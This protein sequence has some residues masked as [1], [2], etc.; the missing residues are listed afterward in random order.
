MEGCVVVPKFV[1]AVPFVVVGALA[2]GLTG[3]EPLP[4]RP[5]LVG[6]E[7]VEFD[8]DV[9]TIHQGQQIQFVNNSNFLHVLAPGDHARVS[10]GDGVPSFG[11]DNVRS[12]PRG[13][14][15]VTGAW[16][17]PGTYDLTCTLHPGMNLEVV[18]EG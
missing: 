2:P 13:D 15:F 14:P 7:Q 3:Q 8:R 10:D 11:P 1:V 5:N 4:R 16:N 9:I 17:E 6:M 18:V 12:M